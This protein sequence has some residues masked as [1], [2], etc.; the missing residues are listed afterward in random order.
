MHAR[1]HSIFDLRFTGTILLGSVLA[2][3]RLAQ[4]QQQPAQVLFDDAA[5]DYMAK[6]Y[7]KAAL[8]FRKAYAVRPEAVFLY[9]QAK[10]LEK[11][12]NWEAA[13]KALERARDQAELPLP[14][15]LA[16]K[17]PSFMEQLEAGLAAERAQKEAAIKPT[18]VVPAAAPN[19]GL[20]LLGWG[21]AGTA[22][23]GGAAVATNFLFASQASSTSDELAATRQRS[24]YD[25]LSQD[26]DE[27]QGTAQALLFVGAGLAAVGAGLLLWDLSN[28]D[29][30]GV[31]VSF[32]A[33]AALVQGRW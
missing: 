12:E 4:A 17:V 27:Q 29:D 11:L 19:D 26:F 3:P 5:A 16:A 28:D 33:G 7:D 24:R 6:R 15:E 13:I 32:G 25:E 2:V 18:V 14:P 9:N 20:S 21:G 23:L 10:A 31:R 30:H 8:G 22:L 1:P